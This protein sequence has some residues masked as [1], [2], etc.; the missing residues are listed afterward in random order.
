MLSIVISF[1]IAEFIYGNIFVFSI[2]SLSLFF[3][4]Y[5]CNIANNMLIM[6][7]FQQI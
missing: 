1:N 6:Y 5:P 3:L 2:F 7:N 4:T